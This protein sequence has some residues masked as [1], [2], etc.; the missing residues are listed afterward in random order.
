MPRL[1][2][3]ASQKEE[4]RAALV[5]GLQL[6]DFDVEDQTKKSNIHNIYVAYVKRIEPSI[7]AAFVDYGV[8]RHGFLSLRN[9]APKYLN[10]K[11]ELEAGTKLIVQIFAD[12]RGHK[13]AALNTFIKIQGNYT[14]L[15][16]F[17][18]K[19]LTLSKKISFANAKKIK[20][21]VEPLIKDSKHSYLMR[22]NSEHHS[23]DIKNDIDFVHK[24]WEVIKKE[25]GQSKKASLLVQE[26]KFIT[27]VI[28]ERLKDNITEIIIDNKE[29]YDEAYNFI[30]KVMPENLDLVKY[31]DHQTVPMFMKYQVERQ[32]ETAYERVVSLPSGGELVFDMTEAMHTVDVNSAHAIKGKAVNQTAVQTNLEAATE[33]ARQMRFRDMSGLCVIDFIDMET[34]EDRTKIY[35]KLRKEMQFDRSRISVTEISKLGLLELT[36]QRLKTSLNDKALRLCD[37]CEGRGRIRG[38]QSMAL[39]ILRNI[40]IEI[41]KNNTAQVRAY[42]SANCAAF[43]LNEKRSKIQ[44]IVE[45]NNIPVYIIPRADLIHPQHKII[46]V[47]QSD[48]TEATLADFISYKSVEYLEDF[49]TDDENNSNNNQKPKVNQEDFRPKSKKSGFFHRFFAS[50]FG[51]SNKKSKPNKKH[52]RRR[53]SRGKR[54]N[55]TNRKKNISK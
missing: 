1:L 24:V 22:S 27:T 45:N 16:T 26:G 9:V 12:E 55:S 42:M 8:Q 25:A 54:S 14:I 15:Q 30:K 49:T 33:V 7:E 2:I 3:N 13:G 44:E 32:L 50:I 19:P 28:K 47:R 43:L 53:R 36:R 11:G 38:I 39:N 6:I 31:Y 23:A 46:R 41:Q 10:A 48:N 34:D 35:N 29:I 21:V 40:E 52:T 51:S 18:D 4:Y 5:D 17:S 20:K 37:V